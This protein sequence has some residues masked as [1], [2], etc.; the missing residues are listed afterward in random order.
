MMVDGGSD[1]VGRRWYKPGGG[2]RWSMEILVGLGK[3]G[4]EN[5]IVL[6]F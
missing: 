4:K 6:S 3:S 2:R 1:V 5:G